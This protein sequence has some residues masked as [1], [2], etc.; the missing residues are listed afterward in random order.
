[1]SAPE[2]RPATV[3]DAPQI[4]AIYNHAVLH[5]VATFEEQ[6]VPD[7]AIALRMQQ[8]KAE[9][10]PYLVHLVDGEIAGYA[11]ANILKPRSAYRFCAET[12]VYVAPKHQRKGIARTLYAVLLRQL[13]E[14]GARSAIG[15][16]TVP[17]PASIALHEQLGFSQVA[18]LKSVGYKFDQW[19][20]VGYWQRMLDA[21]PDS[22][23]AQ[24]E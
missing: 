11:Y 5:T 13:A 10:W 9:G 20:D 1:M 3:E 4:A 15:I 6:P 16:I 21:P 14:G 18:H 19:L 23:A 12:T 7:Q 22:P 24:S 2:I 8:V 17:N